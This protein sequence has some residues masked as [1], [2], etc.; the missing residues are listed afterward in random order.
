MLAYEASASACL[1]LCLAVKQ[2]GSGLVESRRIARTRLAT[3]QNERLGNLANLRF[4][5]SMGSEGFNLTGPGHAAHNAGVICESYLSQAHQDSE[6]LYTSYISFVRLL[7]SD[8]LHTLPLF[9]FTVM[10]NYY[11][12]YPQLPAVALFLSLDSLLGCST[13]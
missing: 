9:F 10:I 12:T 6:I 3:R 2:Q 11:S 8:A 1:C 7:V 4:S 13:P 5:I